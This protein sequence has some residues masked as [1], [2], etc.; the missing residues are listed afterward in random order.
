MKQTR[1]RITG[2]E[3]FYFDYTFLWHPDL[4]KTP[5]LPYHTDVPRRRWRWR[6][7]CAIP[8]YLLLGGRL[9]QRFSLQPASWTHPEILFFV[10]HSLCFL[11]SFPSVSVF[12][13]FLL[14][15]HGH[16]S[17]LSIPYLL[18]QSPGGT[19]HFQ[20]CLVGVRNVGEVV[21]L[22]EDR[23]GWRNIVA[24]VNVDTAHR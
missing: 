12:L 9:L 8:L 19:S 2:S 5:V 6:Q 11:Q 22:A 24:N 10:F 15:V 7:C 16:I 4:R 3:D 17:Y 23:E 21:R 13:C 18:H 20:H 14:S 1:F